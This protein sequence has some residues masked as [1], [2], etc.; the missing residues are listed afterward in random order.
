MPKSEKGTYRIEEQVTIHRSGDRISATIANHLQRAEVWVV[1]GARFTPPFEIYPRMF[2]F[3]EDSIVVFCNGKCSP[4]LL[5]V[6]LHD[7]FDSCER[8]PKI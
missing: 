3:F 6:C 5:A 4:L 2:P 8:I 7:F 1:T